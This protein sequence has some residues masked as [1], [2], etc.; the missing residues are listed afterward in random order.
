[1]VLGAVP[2]L[3][4][5]ASGAMQLSGRRLPRGGRADHRA[6]AVGAAAA[7]GQ[8][9]YWALF[10][11]GVLLTVGALATRWLWHTGA[12]VRLAGRC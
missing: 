7:A 6:G 3:L 9:L 12:G 1:V 4:F 5:L 10:N 11:M 2:N 8:A